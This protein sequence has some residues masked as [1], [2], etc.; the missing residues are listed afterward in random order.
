MRGG[1]QPLFSII[2]PTLNVE[3]VIHVC[4]DSIARQ[5]FQD[6]EVVVH[7]GGST[8]K[9][10]EIIS[11]FKPRL[12]ARLVVQV[13]KD[14]GVYDAMNRAIAEAQGEWLLFLGAD[15][16]L[17]QDA[18]LGEIAAFV[19]DHPT[20]QLV[21]GDVQ[22]RSNSSRYG[23]VFDV[24]KL[25]F[26]K[27]ICHQSIFYRRQ[28]FSTIGPYNLRYPI[29]AD[30]DLNIRCFQNPALIARHMDIV[31]AVYNDTGGLSLKEDAELQKRLPVF[32]LN[33]TKRKWAGRLRAAA[34]YLISGS[35]RRGG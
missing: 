23:G 6:F 16:R 9:T 5:T 15:D 8:D 3:R 28:I 25:L 29:W 31:V 17:Y 12:G 11:T 30:W 33:A 20:S 14:D 24:D 4:L 19:L 21:Y 32:I 26:E 34:R 22:M 10:L 1:G 27:N 18:T 7:D 13:A 35:G 2:V